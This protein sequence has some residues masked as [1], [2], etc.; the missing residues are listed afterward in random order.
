[1]SERGLSPVVGVV[2]LLAVTVLLAAVVVVALP[3]GPP[4]PP[5]A[6]AF[7]LEADP[8]G[9]IRLT[10]AGGEAIEPGAIDLGIRVDGEPIAEQPPVPFFSARGFESAPEGAFNSALSEPWV[11]GETATLTLA[12]T[13][14]PSI[15]AGDAVAVRVYV[16]DHRVATLETTA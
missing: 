11:A 2:C 15:D 3:T 16:D 4:S 7:E 5:T 14:E 10:H 9:E 1:M 13:N 6:A 8:G 12:G